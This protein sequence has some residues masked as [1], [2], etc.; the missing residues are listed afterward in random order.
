M[1]NNKTR[2]FERLTKEE[3]IEEYNCTYKA[4]DE[5]L[6]DYAR[7]KIH[8]ILEDNPNYSNNDISYIIQDSLDSK[9]IY[10]LVLTDDGGD[11]MMINIFDNLKS[12]NAFDWDFSFDSNLFYYLECGYE[13]KYMDEVTHNAILSELQY[14]YPHSIDNI[15]G[16]KRYAEYCEENNI[17]VKELAKL[18]QNVKE[19]NRIL[20]SNNY[21]VM[22]IPQIDE[23]PPK[24]SKVYEHSITKK[25][26]LEEFKALIKNNISC[27]SE[28]HFISKPK[29]G[30]EKEWNLEHARLKVIDEIIKDENK[31]V[32]EQKNK[33]DRCL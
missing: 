27:Y 13:I 26:L 31:L 33:E 7:E 11:G 1:T 24:T 15:E 3:Y 18:E 4:Y 9:D 20:I 21:E 30:Y 2:D 23:K 16:V 32:L 12:Y 22:D 25:E 10:A 28:G 6:V 14:Y 8:K 5:V 19:F 17:N 29:R